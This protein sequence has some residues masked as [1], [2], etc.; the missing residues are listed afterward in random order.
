MIQ[1]PIGLWISLIQICSNKFDSNNMFDCSS[2][3]NPFSK[4]DCATVKDIKQ[5]STNIKDSSKEVLKVL[6][7]QLVELLCISNKDIYSK[8]D[9]CHQM[10]G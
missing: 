9:S 6:W 5:G 10:K 1:F 7:A 3:L 8:L 2:I 4:D